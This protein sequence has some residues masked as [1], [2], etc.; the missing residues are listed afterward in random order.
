MP[1]LVQRKE[2]LP[3]LSDPTFMGRVIDAVEGVL[4]E[5]H[6]GEALNYAYLHMPLQAG[7]HLSV[8]PA[9]SP[10]IGAC[11]RV[12]PAFGGGRPQPD[13]RVIILF[14]GKNGQ[15]LGLLADDD[16]NVVRT[17]APG[18]VACRHLA[19]SNVKRMAMLGSGR[20]ARGQLLAIL[21][22]LP[23][24]EHVRVYSPTPANRAAFA[25]EMNARLAVDVTATATA[26][27][28]VEGAQVIALA[29]NAGKPVLEAEWISVGALLVSIA[30][31]Q[32]PSQ[33]VARS[34]LFVSIRERFLEEKREPYFSLDAAGSWSYERMK[35][36][37]EVIVGKVRARENPDEIV[38]CELTGMPLW[39]GAIANLAFTW[40][41]ENRVGTHFHLSAE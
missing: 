25:K 7:G 2:L 15:L 23:S 1:V 29:T 6:R 41:K 32:I 16:L 21:Q 14:D 28:A 18:G 8:L 26:R 4:A 35:E 12:S 5:H 24:I 3:L 27:E 30:V 37:G 31:N 9:I 22:A 17:G 11:L 19:P 40:A 36:L 33:L 20:Q 10:T 39:D 34:R 13:S 38:I